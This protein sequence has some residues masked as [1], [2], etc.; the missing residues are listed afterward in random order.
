MSLK[1]SW[2]WPKNGYREQPY[3]STKWYPKDML[4][5]AFQMW[6]VR[7]V[8]GIVSGIFN[9]FRGNLQDQK[10]KKWLF[11]PIYDLFK[12]KW[13]LIEMPYNAYWM[14]D[15]RWVSGIFSGMHNFQHWIRLCRGN[16]H[17]RNWPFI[18]ISDEFKYK[19]GIWWKCRILHSRCEIWDDIP[20]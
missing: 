5:M 6:N 14:Q 13:H 11:I 1:M 19:N 12:Y 18:L 16:L 4:D 8:S 2:K 7:W 15:V 10:C 17:G 20:A 9:L 3:L